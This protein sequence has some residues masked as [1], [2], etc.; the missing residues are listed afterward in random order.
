MFSLGTVT[1]SAPMALS[2]LDDYCV[3][4]DFIIPLGFAAW[5]SKNYDIKY[6]MGDELNEE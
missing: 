3:R 5:L 1:T 2:H 6:R 4:L